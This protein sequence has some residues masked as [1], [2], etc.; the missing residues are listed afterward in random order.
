MDIDWHSYGNHAFSI[1]EL[2]PPMQGAITLLRRSENF[3][4]EVY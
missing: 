2:Q 3:R 1:S 4:I